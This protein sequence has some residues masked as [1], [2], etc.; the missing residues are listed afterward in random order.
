MSITEI[1]KNEI[2]LDIPQNTSHIE[3]IEH[4][5][6][7][8]CRRLWD[9]FCCF[10]KAIGSQNLLYDDEELI[11]QTPPFSAE[12]HSKER[13]R[14]YKTDVAIMK[15]TLTSKFK[16][17]EVGI[18]EE[19]N[20]DLIIAFTLSEQIGGEKLKITPKYL[21]SHD[22]M[23][24]GPASPLSKVAI[25]TLI[26]GLTGLSYFTTGQGIMTKEC[27]SAL[28]PLALDS[29][30]RLPYVPQI[31]TPVGIFAASYLVELIADNPLSTFA[32]VL[33][34]ALIAGIFN[35]M[36]KGITMGGWSSIKPF[37]L[38][39]PLTEIGAQTF[40]KR[41]ICCSKR[42]AEKADEASAE[43]KDRKIIAKIPVAPLDPL[44]NT[45]EYDVAIELSSFD[46][47]MWYRI[48]VGNVRQNWI[49][50][51][52]GQKDVDDD[53]DDQDVQK[54]ICLN[55]LNETAPSVPDEM[56]HNKQFCSSYVPR[57]MRDCDPIPDWIK[58]HIKEGL[59]FA[60]S[61]ITTAMSLRLWDE[62][63]ITAAA[64]S[65]HQA[66][67]KA[68]L[69][70]WPMGNAYGVL[71]LASG[72]L[73]LVNVLTDSFIGNLYFMPLSVLTGMFIKQVVKDAVISGRPPKNDQIFALP[74]FVQ[75]LRHN[76]T[77]WAPHPNSP[78]KENPL[79]LPV[80]EKANQKALRIDID[81]RLISAQNKSEDKVPLKLK[82]A[83]GKLKGTF[84]VSES[85]KE[86][87]LV[88]TKA[89]KMGPLAE[90]IYNVACIS[91]TYAL[92]GIFGQGVVANVFNKSF[93][94][95]MKRKGKDLTPVQ[96]TGG[97]IIICGITLSIDRF[98]LEP[99]GIDFQLSI[100]PLSAALSMLS[101]Q[102]KMW[103]IG[104]SYS[105]G[106]AWV[107]KGEDKAW[108]ILRS[109][110]KKVFNCKKEEIAGYLENVDDLSMITITPLDDEIT[111]VMIHNDEGC[112]SELVQQ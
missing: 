75:Q 85:Q 10:T 104:E 1:N 98:I 11:V 17:E 45:L 41:V 60:G 93:S 32:G 35:R 56:N 68:I 19:G 9:T 108:E 27:I 40:A 95:Y 84:E 33:S 5:H 36:G 22:H 2:E 94:A 58:Q 3:I 44:K 72:T 30:K 99:R 26:L 74:I 24:K 80:L 76:L 25:S 48:C 29:F 82:I 97:S 49:S 102:A 91:L 50:M 38:S 100:V 107:W 111:E 90:V 92:S 109:T 103:A 20:A 42:E 57:S 21:V 73:I 8:L 65:I 4:Q 83:G 86:L 54:T 78:G 34:L 81:P 87:A 31:V 46:K 67:T 28:I 112:L 61:G 37:L 89:K 77:G 15:Q 18:E 62:G 23:R 55:R 12:E 39:P 71:A 51:S 43:D 52:A 66:S 106:D 6:T 16:K 47:E 59:L 105:K 70:G 110:A 101:I 96:R 69:R 79:L 88:R 7:S 13:E 64:N 63:L 14:I 53:D